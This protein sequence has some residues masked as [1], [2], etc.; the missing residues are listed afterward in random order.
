MHASLMIWAVLG[1]SQKS[2]RAV[3]YVGPRQVWMWLVLGG[4]LIEGPGGGGA[5]QDGPGPAA[6]MVQHPCS[7]ALG[8]PIVYSYQESFF[9]GCLG[10]SGGQ[11]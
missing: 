1:K 11:R 10:G 9:T 8:W 6:I 3:Q 4:F 2:P 5:H 7:V